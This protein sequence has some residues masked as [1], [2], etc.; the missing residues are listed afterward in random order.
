MKT[1]VLL[2]GLVV[3]A[4]ACGHSTPGSSPADAATTSDGASA[5]DVAGGSPIVATTNQWTWVDVAGSSCD[6]GTPTGIAV[7]P[8]TGGD[9]FVYFEGGGAC[10]DYATCFVLNTT[11]HGPFGH[12]QWNAAVGGAGVGPFDRARATN[13]FRASTY[14]FVPYC[15]GDLH[16]GTHV[17]AYVGPTDTRTMRHVGRKN[18]ELALARLRATWPS[19]PRVVVSGTSAGGYGASFNYALFRDAFP[20]A[21]MAL[22]DDAGPLLEGNGIPADLRAAFYSMWHL[23]DV[24]T[25]LCPTCADD[26]SGLQAALAARH[27]NDRLGL[28]SSLAD[29]VIGAYFRLTADQF[30]ASLNTTVKDRY[31]P[32]PNARAYLVAGTQHGFLPLAATTK[33]HDVTLDA[34]LDALANGGAGWDTVTP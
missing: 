19:P 6:D 14:V 17:Q 23:G 25:P 1:I 16:A 9:L 28:L 32:T 18:A 10:W 20:V 27:P 5:P 12:A 31:A 29:P 13:P 34:W 11:L 8:G 2:S 7:N 21:R 22:V 33:S 4:V 15:T 24:V 3:L 30:Q 26:L